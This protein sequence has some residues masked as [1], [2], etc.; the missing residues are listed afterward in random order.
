M[1]WLIL[2]TALFI[3]VI[4]IIEG[5]PRDYDTWPVMLNHFLATVS[6]IMIIVWVV[7]L[8]SEGYIDLGL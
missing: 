3:V 5:D 6:I 8:L 1:G 2:L 4:C 7:K